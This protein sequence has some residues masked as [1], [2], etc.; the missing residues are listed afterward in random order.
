MK[1]VLAADIF[2]P[3]SG[4]P[5][6]YVV[7][8][9]NKLAQPEY[10][11]TVRIVSLNPNSDQTKALCPVYTVRS[12]H[13]MLRYLH[14][15]FLLFKHGKD[16]DVIY[17][18]G[19][20]NAGF[21]AYLAARV[22]RKRC[23][24]KVVGDY[25]WEQWQNRG[26]PFVSLETFQTMSLTGSIARLRNIERWVCGRADLVIVPSQ[27]L[28]RIVIGWGVE[29]NNVQVIYNAVDVASPS[30]VSKPKGEQWVVSV[31][32][33]VPW[34]GMETLIEVMRGLIEKYP[35]I[36][37]KIIGDGPEFASLQSKV[38]SFKLEDIVALLG[39][40]S[41]EETLAYMVAADVIVLNSAYE[42][43]SHVLL[44]ALSLRR[45]VVASRC[46]GN[47]E[48]ITDG[49]NGYLFSYNDI[50]AI[51]KSIEKII[52]GGAFH[53]SGFEE[54][55]EKEF[56]LETMFARTMDVL[57]GEKNHRAS[58]RL[59]I[60]LDHRILDATSAVAERMKH[61]GEEQPL[62][63]FIPNREPKKVE[64][65]PM[66]SVYAFG[67][68][69]KIQQFFR[70]VQIGSQAVSKGGIREVT[71]QDPFFTGLIGYSIARRHHIP[72][73]VQLH[74][75]FFGSAYYR[76][77]SF[78]NFFR[79]ALGRF[80][81]GKADRVR[82]VGERVRQS[83]LHLGI[84]DEKIKV[85]AVSVDASTIASYH[86]RFSL[87]DRYPN[88]SPIFLILGRL[89]PVKNI[90]WIV[91]VFRRAQQEQP[92][93]LLL[94]VGD[95][96]ELS[97]LKKCVLAQ[98]LENAV[99]FEIWT[100][101]PWGYLKGADCVLFPSL[102]EGYGLVAVETVAAGTPLIINDVGVAGFEVKEGEKVR[103]IPVAKK[104]E[105]VDEMKKTVCIHDRID[106]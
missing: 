92:N 6:T 45:P 36:R 16:A 86:P 77:S 28:R 11:H 82:V 42:G 87:H 75:D 35:R 47:P 69:S 98:G 32:R 103:I 96:S 22:R 33:L 27:Y 68:T 37:L 99:R 14:Y 90:E 79:Y 51:A 15:F 70:L 94:I 18:M 80:L 9:G 24:V 57:R 53:S 26:N 56:S 97:C 58:M 25:A 29:S 91:D 60:S 46:G 106:H 30:P 52:A 63:I 55:R 54:G 31:G 38:K 105:W 89:D 23:V 20:V 95:G 10:A 59:M 12:K 83:V 67:G 66:A 2:P 61:Y 34:K 40:L 88:F 13:K 17:A 78:M 74:G 100:T 50:Y 48:L 8:L 71:T 72:W 73:E 39:S 41:R 101:D 62:L 84:P 21:P 81:I 19:P 49:R 7:A 65:S 1:I 102:S 104:Q 3:E 44:E 76:K 64:L 85:R 5:A 4:G 93:A 43:L